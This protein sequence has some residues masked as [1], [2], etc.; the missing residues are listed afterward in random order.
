MKSITF[1]FPTL[2]T[3]FLAG[4]V[5]GTVIAYAPAP[6]SA[7][8][9]APARPQDDNKTS[10]LPFF[11]GGSAIS[12]TTVTAYT[13]NGGSATL[14]YYIFL[15]SGTDQSAVRVSNS[16]SLI[17]TNSII[18][19]TS[20]TSSQQ[21]SSFH[22]LN[23]GVLALSGSTIVIS[24]SLLTTTG[25]GANGAF[26]NGTGSVVVLNK[27]TMRATGEAGHGVMATEGGAV[28]LTNVDIST[29]GS[30]SAPLATDRGGGTVVA[31]GGT[32][33]TSG[34]D[35]PGVYST[36]VITVTGAVITCTG[37][38]AAVIEGANTIA[39]ID[40]TLSSSQENKWGVMIYQSMS[41][42]AQGAR[43][44][45][46]VSGGVLANTAT[47]GPLFYVTNSTALI[48]LHDAQATAASGT[49]LKAGAGNW[50]N[51][52]SNGGTANLTADSQTLAGNL[53]ADSISSIAATLQNGSALTGAINAEHTASSV[54]LTLD[55]T[56]A[57]T[58][59]A[60]SYLTCLADPA[61]ISGG[62][63]T[64]IT[65]NG[66]SVYYDSSACSALGGQTY[67]LNGGG[68][69]TPAP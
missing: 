69:L 58:V 48:T 62:S 4:A 53:V 56:S 12:R 40:T 11:T 1:L 35:S 7:T 15:A 39:L 60:N 42:D 52:G 13:Q 32:I 46:T 3:L 55:A 5:A 37:A 65:G 66:H 64:N 16:G 17:V 25:A 19:S 14:G 18:S 8:T 30:H 38:E 41:G 44:I 23:A 27:V 68:S 63:V 36:G 61:G 28:T 33:T 10:Y 29:A 2:A 20:D 21:D 31:T 49:L 9:D 34:Q 59:T 50:G 26:A 6:A 54:N 45:F 24:D 43:G 51:S 67:A 22:G 47:T 57:W